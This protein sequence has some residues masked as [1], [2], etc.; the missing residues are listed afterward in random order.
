MYLVVEESPFTLSQVFTLPTANRTHIKTV[1][2][3]LFLNNPLAGSEIT[4]SIH[5]SVGN[6]IHSEN[7]LL[8]DI[9]TQMGIS[10]AFGH[11]KY[12]WTP[13]SQVRL[14]RGSYTV[15]M[16]HSVNYGLDNFIAWCKDWEGPYFPLSLAS[17]GDKND[18]FYLRLYDHMDR[19][20]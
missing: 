7:V 15:R 3:W 11:G 6:Q 14:G 10:D 5:D 20:I 4:L 13:S 9:K 17:D 19:A 18:P 16:N 8:A 2:L 12:I 1:T